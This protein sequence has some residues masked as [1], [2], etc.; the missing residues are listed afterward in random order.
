M[1]TGDKILPRESLRA[2]LDAARASGKQIVLANG[3]FDLLHSG[4]V[5]Y[6]EAAKREGD[7]LVVAVNSDSSARQLKGPGRPVLHERG[8]AEL[9]AALAAVDFVVI[10]DELNVEATLEALRPHVHAKGTDYTAETVPERSTS[11][12]LGMRIAIVGDPKNHSTSRFFAGLRQQ[13]AQS[14]TPNQASSTIHVE[15]PKRILIVRL[16]S[17]GDIL[18]AVPVA[19]ALR[20]AFPLAHIAW[21]ADERWRALVEQ[22]QGLDAVVSIPRD[23]WGGIRAGIEQARRARF[24]TVLDVQGLY[25]SALLARL[26]GAPTRVGFDRRSARESGAALFYSVRVSPPHGHRIEKNLALAARLGAACAPRG[27]P[28]SQLF[29]LRVSAEAESAFYQRLRAENVNGYFVLAPGG[30]WR[31]KCWPAERFGELHR[32]LARRTGLCG[33]LSYGPGE[34]PL[35]QAVQKAAGS[36]PPLL[37]ELDLAQ[38]MAALRGAQFFIGGDTGP[39][40]LAVALGTPVVG[41]YGPTDP[42]QTGP[43][44]RDDI[45]VRNAEPHETTYERNTDYSPT[46]LSITVDQAEEAALRRLAALGSRGRLEAAA[47]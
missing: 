33:L 26:S 15:Q 7:L 6:L 31:S 34:L 18:H 8:R 47:R 25:K 14:A 27:L 23:S 45:V 11:A 12:R 38:L 44:T 3:I 41:L 17:M 39:L 13:R 43:Y 5:R 30:G 32:R 21:L 29:P 9:V 37:V 42:E 2:R 28:V 36:P 1:N 22:I 40:H 10:F 46:M 16:S 19:T 4:H 24:D 35:A 20:A